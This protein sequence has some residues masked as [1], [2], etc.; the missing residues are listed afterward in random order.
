VE[1]DEFAAITGPI[2]IAA[3]ETDDIFP[4]ELRVK[5]EEVLKKTGRI[6][7]LS[8][9]SGVVHGF[10]SAEHDSDG[11]H[12]KYAQEQSFLQAVNFFNYFLV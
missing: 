9:Y 8:L 4:T 11:V 6:Y 2:S 3:A 5:T 7:Q 10:F 12:A 1:E